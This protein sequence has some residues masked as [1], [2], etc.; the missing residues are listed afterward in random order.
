MNATI[1]HQKVF[2]RLLDDLIGAE[3]VN[4]AAP[5]PRPIPRGWTRRQVER[6]VAL[7]RRAEVCE[8]EAFDAGYRAKRIEQHILRSYR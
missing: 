7:T 3:N 4:Q 1:D 2:R 5:F 6:F 8:R